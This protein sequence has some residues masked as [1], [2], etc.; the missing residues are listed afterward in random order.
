MLTNPQHDGL[1]YEW[2]PILAIGEVAITNGSITSSGNWEMSPKRL[3]SATS[4]RL[5][6]LQNEPQEARFRQLLD[7]QSGNLENESQEV[8]FHLFVDLLAS[9]R[10]LDLHACSSR[11]SRVFDVLGSPDMF[12]PTFSRL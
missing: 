12:K 9:L 8:R 10:F 11:P 6:M 3:H 1:P 4:D 5:E 2:G 7:A